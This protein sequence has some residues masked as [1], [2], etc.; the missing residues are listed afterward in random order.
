MQ[1]DASCEE[2]E[3]KKHNTNPFDGP[4]SGD[5][6]VV[7]EAGNA[8]KVPKGNW[9]TGTK[10]GKWIQE[11][12]PGGGPKGEPTGQR[13]DG[14]GH[15]PPKHTDVRANEPHA[16]VPDVTNPDGTNWLP[17]KKQ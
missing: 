7:D 12:K 1:F 2:E 14:G 11:M 4:V 5:V 10:D 16:H 13:K 6:V 3:R 15:S 9:L 8:I 17:L